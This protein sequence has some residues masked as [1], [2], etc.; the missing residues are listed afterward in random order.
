MIE[1]N[2]WRRST[3]SKLRC[4][5]GCQPPRMLAGLPPT[6][7]SSSFLLSSLESIDTKSLWTLITSPPRKHFTFL[8]RIFSEIEKSLPPFNTRS[9]SGRWRTGRNKEVVNFGAGHERR[10]ISFLGRV[11]VLRG[12]SSGTCSDLSA[13]YCRLPYLCGSARVGA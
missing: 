9:F 2:T 1:R 8:R 11:C 10:Q 12:G 13:S 6:S 7:F 3:E 4:L 5:P